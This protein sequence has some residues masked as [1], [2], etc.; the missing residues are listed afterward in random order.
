MSEFYRIN[1][2]P[3][4]RRARVTR[5]GHAYVDERTKEDL[6][7][8]RNAYKGKLY[9]CPVK[10]VVVVYKSLTKSAPKSLEH[11]PFTQKPDAD[12][13]LKACLDGLNGV[14]YLDDSQVVEAHVYKRER[15][16]APGEY[17]SF[18]VFPVKG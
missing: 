8:V 18:A 4:K 11:E 2:I 10:V 6:Q 3:I 15:T 12:N 9:R 14:A 16:H 17:C 1:R 13:I 7:A 5:S